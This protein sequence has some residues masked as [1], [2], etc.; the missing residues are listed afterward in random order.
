MSKK[1]FRVL[2]I[3]GG[4]MRGLYTAQ[5][6]SILAQRFDPKFKEVSPD[7]GKAFDLIC[8]TST[9]AI[10]ACALASGISIKNVDSLY[11]KYGSKIFIDP[12]PSAGNSPL[13]YMWAWRNRKKAA[14][15][16][17]QLR[18]ALAETFG[19]MTIKQL[20]EKRKI[21]LCIPS[22]NAQNHRAW[23]FKT[24]HNSGKTRDDNYSLV[25]VC[26]AS[27]AAPILFPIA[28]FT[29]PDN[30]E[31]LDSF[32]DGGLWA[33]NPA[34]IGLIEAL[35]MVDSKTQKLEVLSIGTCDRPSG[36]PYS[37][38]NPNWGV[39]N[40][41][42]GMNIV[43][44]SLSAQSFGYT[45]AAKFL[46]TSLTK[47][48]METRVVRLEQ[49]NKSPE[50]YSAINIDKADDLA[51]KT[52]SEMARTDAEDIHSKALGNNPGDLDF[53]KEIFLNLSVV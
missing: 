51:L 28:Q 35:G 16:A 9:G 17:N 38:K 40:W 29:N 25:D 15:N 24:P 14:A 20:Y 13:M 44:M 41:K 52:L 30:K 49:T 11:R 6:L 2:C 37:V 42:V 21:A 53:V 1:P 23:V 4:G 18:E 3:D 33:N 32:I 47:L 27:A 39:G 26:M 19:S 48:G 45:N 8:G 43:E 5:L 7:F 22:I 12:M 10:L 36:D 31:N 34:L 50:Q 46:G